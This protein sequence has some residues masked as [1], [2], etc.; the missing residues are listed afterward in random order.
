MFPN[1]RKRA[2][3][4]KHDKPT[5]P[6]FVCA[7][8]PTLADV[9]RAIDARTGLSDCRKR[10]LLSG[11][12]RVGKIN[13]RDLKDISLHPKQLR[14]LLVPGAPATEHLSRKSLQ[15]L[16]SDLAA[17]IALSGLRPLLRTARAKLNPAWVGCRA[18]VTDKGISAVLYRLSAFCSARGISPED[19]N[20]AVMAGYAAALENE[21]LVRHPDKTLK[22]A[23][24]GWNKACATVEG[25]PG[26]TVS[27]F[28]VGREPKRISLT[29]FPKSLG[30]DIDR[31]LD[32]CLV[33]D[34]FADDARG[35][36]LAPSTVH[37]R[38]SHIHTALDVAVGQ[39]ISPESLTRLGE[40]VTPEVVKRI[41]RGLLARHGGTAN[42][43]ASSVATTLVTIAKEWVKVRPIRLPS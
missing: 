29:A 5:S 13:N 43:Y 36:A 1:S 21:S 3:P 15:N 31:Y 2:N 10:D 32:H 30:E 35:K 7:A 11:V 22:M 26:A 28:R 40:L 41:F 37:L 12:R 20:D 25:F 38:R 34:P 42:A 17:A 27:G 14:G 19:V 6:N 18:L 23:I 24:W 33:S 4:V 9:E 39:G 16:R 8:E